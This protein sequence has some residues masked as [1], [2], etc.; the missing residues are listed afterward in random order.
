M[1]EKVQAT[2]EEV[3]TTDDSIKALKEK[4]GAVPHVLYA[5]RSER[6]PVDAVRAASQD[7]VKKVIRFRDQ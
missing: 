1:A 4:L 6:L 3:P 7:L 2:I 5:L